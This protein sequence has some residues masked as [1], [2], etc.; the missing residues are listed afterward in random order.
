MEI[1]KFWFLRSKIVV[2]LTSMDLCAII[3]KI[4]S[5]FRK[6]ET[7]CCCLMSKFIENF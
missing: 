6:V 4:L 3:S 2:V 7:K 5:F 1:F